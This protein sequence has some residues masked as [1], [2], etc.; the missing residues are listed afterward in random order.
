MDE[1]DLQI[2]LTLAENGNLTRTAEKLYLAQPTLSKRLQNMEAEL[3]TQLFL[4]SKQGVTLTPAGEAARETIRH[5]VDEF[6]KLRAFIQKNQGYVGGTLRVC[7]SLDY[8]T[9]RLPQVLAAYMTQFPNVKLQVS[10][11]HSRDCVRILQEGKIHAAVVRG[12]YDWS[13]GKILLEQE[14]V[15][16]IRSRAVADVPLNRQHYIGRDANPEHMSMKARWL[17]ENGLEPAVSLNV[18]G[19]SACVSMVQA[20]LGW[21][22]VPQICLNGFDGIVE[23][24]FFKDGTP[25]TRPT[26][27]L[28]RKR[29]FELPQV[30]EFV[31]IVCAQSQG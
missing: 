24:L 6:E 2:F 4:R 9:Y 22:I 7:A 11:E 1:K 19:L 20:G 15:C 14:P 21:S 30:R 23:P 8:S 3:G 10:S 17:M 27:L 25:L 26:Y 29:D 28:Y 18:N 13:E 5:T 12:N 16:L 31:R